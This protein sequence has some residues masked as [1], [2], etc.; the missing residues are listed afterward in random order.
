MRPTLALLLALPVLGQAPWPDIT[1]PKS[2]WE[3]ARQRDQI[4]EPA[5]LLESRIQVSRD[6]VERWLRLRILDE[7]GREAAAFTPTTR[8]RGRILLPDGSARTF[9]RLSQMEELTTPDGTSRLRP[10]NLPSDCL[11]ELHLESEDPL[12]KAEAAMGRRTLGFFPWKGFLSQ[13]PLQGPLPARLTLL[14]V[15]GGVGAT[16]LGGKTSPF[17]VEESTSPD[18]YVATF[19][20]LPSASG[21]SGDLCFFWFPTGGTLPTPRQDPGTYWEKTAPR[22]L[23]RVFSDGVEAGLPFH[24]RKGPYLK[25]L[26]VQPEAA[27]LELLTRLRMA[28]RLSPLTLDDLAE[29]PEEFQRIPDPW[30]VA[31]TLSAKVATGRGMFHAALRL[32]RSADLPVRILLV[33]DPAIRPFR[34]DLPTIHQFTDAFLGFP[35][36]E[37]TLRWFDPAGDPA[38]GFPVQPD[39]LKAPGMILD[40]ASWSL[41]PR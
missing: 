20:N 23:E 17:L 35:T 38:T 37:G 40:P 24:L 15:T 8:W 39:L 12:G 36:T 16:W 3:M 7:K 31:E 5:L 27:G 9:N 4:P 29:A 32:A 11:L 14:E 13:M 22:D 34:R 26:P 18:S 19:R 21:G 25:N 10:R 41:L 30:D 33:T 2:V 6:R 1:V 28:I